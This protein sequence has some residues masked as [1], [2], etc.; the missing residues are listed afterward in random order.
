MA[1]KF[2]KFFG[3]LC[4][5]TFIFSATSQIAEAATIEYADESLQGLLTEDEIQDII[6]SN[7]EAS[8]ITIWDVGFCTPEENQNEDYGI[9]PAV[10]GYMNKNIRTEK[11]LLNSNYQISDL[12]ITSVAKGETYALESEYSATE[13][14]SFS[15]DIFDS[16]KLNLSSSLTFT[17]AQSWVFQ[18]PP[19]TAEYKN[20]NSREYRVKFIGNY[21]SYAQTADIYSYESSNPVTL[22]F[23]F[24]ERTETKTGTYIEPVKFSAYSFDTYITK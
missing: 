15:G 24:Y 6:N 13:S 14:S 2:L 5:S 8:V 1:K 7:P 9:M 19:D 10:M 4:A 11:T 16:S 22:M 18:G 20:V 17:R 21:G 12:F 3:A 23:P